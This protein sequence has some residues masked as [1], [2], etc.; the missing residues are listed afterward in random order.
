MKRMAICAVAAA[1]ALSMTGPAHAGERAKADVLCQPTD[2]D[3]VYDCTILLMSKKSGKPLADAEIVVKVDMPS[4]AMA[5]NV[6]P[7][8]A[9]AGH[10]PGHYNATLELE[11]YGEWALI[12]DVSGP[13]RDRIIRKLQFGKIMAHGNGE[14]KHDK[15]DMGAMKKMKHDMGEMKKMKPAD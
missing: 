7:V 12:L 15:G 3:L 13:T 5:H 14:M 10:M 11:M 2:K 6:R 9:T 4:M 8:T 1:A